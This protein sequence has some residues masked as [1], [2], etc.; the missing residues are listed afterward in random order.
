MFRE[1]LNLGE[2]LWDWNYILEPISAYV[3]DVE[4]HELKFLEARVDFFKKHKYQ[5]R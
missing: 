4:K 5:L 2:K 1:Y 3:R